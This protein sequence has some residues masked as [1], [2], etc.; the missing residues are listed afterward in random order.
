MFNL[1]QFQFNRLTQLMKKSSALGWTVNL[2]LL[3]LVQE[4]LKKPSQKLEAQVFYYN[5]EDISRE[6]AR[7]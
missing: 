6:T 4:T 2:N 5:R 3:F 7:N 1:V